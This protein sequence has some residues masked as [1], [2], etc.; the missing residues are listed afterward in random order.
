MIFRN[1]SISSRK[2][3]PGTWHDINFKKFQTFNDLPIPLTNTSKA[4]CIGNQIPTEFK[5]RISN[6][7][8][9]S[10]SFKKP[11]FESIFI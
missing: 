3:R 2:P 8:R 11:Q 6:F 9:N 7:Q 10:L 5:H 1:P 4:P